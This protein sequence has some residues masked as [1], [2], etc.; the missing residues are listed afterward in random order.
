MDKASLG[1]IFLALGGIIAGLLLEGGNLG[2]ILQPTAAMI[3]FGGTIGAVLVQFPLPVI[4]ASGKGLARVFFER[5]VNIEGV[6]KEIV[7]YANKARK[8]GIISLDRDLENITDPFLKKSL[9]LAIDGTEPQELKKMMELELENQA[10]HEEKIPQVFESAGGFS[11][12]I[13]IIGAVLGLIQVMQRLDNIEEVGK[14]IAVAFVATVYGV[15]AANLFFL[16]S[17]GKLKIRVREEQLIRE[18]MLE[19]VIS[20]LEGLNPRM[21]ETKLKGF[22]ADRNEKAKASAKASVKEPVAS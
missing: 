8:E 6:I 17:A 15:G 11:P 21:V 20:I 22:L 18:M 13:G 7:G 4:L 19:G 2:Q 14:G 3:V 5:K 12:T 10:E 1:G 9:M 16:P